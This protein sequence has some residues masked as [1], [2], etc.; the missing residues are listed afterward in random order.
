MSVLR[1]VVISAVLVT[2]AWPADAAVTT[3]ARARA[4]K[5]AATAPAPKPDAREGRRLDDIHIEG[6]IAVPQVL[7]ITARDQRRFLDFQHHRYLKTSVAVGEAATFPS[8]IAATPGP[9]LDARKE[10]AP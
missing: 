2:L 4:R 7:F 8:R 10:T 3:R 6:E 9:S 1:A 5:P